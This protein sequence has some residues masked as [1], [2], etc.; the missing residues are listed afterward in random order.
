MED[1][2]DGAGQLA[3]L[4]PLRANLLAGDLRMFYLLWLT[5]VEA[6]VF[7][8]DTPEPLPGVGPLDGSAG[9]IRRFFSN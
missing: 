2:D 1:F 6:D 5:A 9:S 8:N 3:A 7:A 4:A